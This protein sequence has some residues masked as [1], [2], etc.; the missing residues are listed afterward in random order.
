MIGGG[1]VLHYW[2]TPLAEDI[3]LTCQ[4]YLVY[5]DGGPS[6]VCTVQ[7]RGEHRTW[8]NKD[9][10]PRFGNTEEAA[11]WINGKALDKQ[12][13]CM[14]PPDLDGYA[15]ITFRGESGQRT[16]YLLHE[17]FHLMMIELTQDGQRCLLVA[18]AEGREEAD[19]LVTEVLDFVR[20][21]ELTWLESYDFDFSQPLS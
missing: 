19:A 1:V 16:E 6:E 12:F 4:G 5:V 20:Q 21:R 7:V 14:F 8:M 18:P 11:F 2:R 17:D 10:W 3:N 15:S 13:S 9:V